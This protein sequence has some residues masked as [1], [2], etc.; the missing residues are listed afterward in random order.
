[1]KCWAA[2]EGQTSSHPIG[3]WGL[4]PL[5]AQ[6]PGNSVSMEGTQV[7]LCLV[8]LS[9]G[10]VEDGFEGD[11]TW[12]QRSEKRVGEVLPYREGKGRAG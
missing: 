4:P 5:G 8:R 3:S 7:D 1:M 10:T 9:G 12:R 2:E 11:K 6:G